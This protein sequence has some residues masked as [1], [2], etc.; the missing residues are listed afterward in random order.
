MQRRRKRVC[1]LSRAST[2]PGPILTNS[3]ARLSI[4]QLGFATLEELVRDWEEDHLKWDANDL[5][6][7]I[8]TWQHADIG[9]NPLYRGDFDARFAIHPRAGDRDALPVRICISCR[10]TT[11]LEVEKM[12]HAQLRVFHTPWGHCVGSPGR[13]PE[14]QQ[15]LDEAAAELLRG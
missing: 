6:A 14:F 5:L 10:K 8:W 9:D 2:L 13:V 7:K 12:P 15:A 1:A 11:R 3:S 4:A